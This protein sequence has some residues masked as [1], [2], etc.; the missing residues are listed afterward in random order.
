MSDFQANLEQL[1][2]ILE[3]LRSP[4]E[5]DGHPWAQSL[6]AQAQPGG[7]PGEK[8]ALAIRH[9]FRELLPAQPPRRGKRL[10]THWGAFGIL[11]AQYFVPQEF[12]LPEPQS[13]REAWLGID[14]AILLYVF[15]SDVEINPEQRKRYCLVGNEPEVAP[16][17]T[18]SGWN[19]KGLEALLEV[20][21]HH[22]AALKAAL[23]KKTLFEPA[24]GTAPAIDSLH[25]KTR[26]WRNVALMLGLLLLVF[27]LWTGWQGYRLYRQTQVV[28][29][30]VSSLKPV[31]TSLP[32]AGQIGAVAGQVTTLRQ[33]LSVL[34]TQAEPFLW[35]APYMRWVPTYG[36]DISQAPKILDMATALVA[37]A[38]EGLQVV[39]PVAKTVSDK[40][41]PLD[42]LVLLNQLQQEQP[43]LLAAQ[44][45]L[46][47]AQQARG[48]I[49]DHLLS[50]KTR[51]ILTGQID[52][53]LQ[54]VQGKF[55][56]EDALL[57]VKAAPGLLGV[58][59]AGPK[60]Y[61]LLIQNEDELRPTGGFITAVGSVVIRDG[62]LWDIKIESSELINDFSKPY[63]KAPWQLD[64]YMS[65]P[66]LVFSDSN[67]FSDFPTTAS[68]AEYL[69]SY[70]RAHSV[71]G[72]I[73]IN[74][75]VVVE[76]LKTLGPLNVPGLSF[77]INSDNILQ[78]MRTAKQHSPPGFVG[79][80]DR[81]LFIGKLAQPLL[82]KIL[83]AR[84]VQLSAL[85]QTL[86]K[87]LDERDILLQFDDPDLTTF[88]AQR[89]W[90]GAVRPPANS[91][92]LLLVDANVGYNKTHAV[93][94][95]ALTYELN[96]ADPA[97]PL[98][99]LTVN[100]TNHATGSLPCVP[101]PPGRVDDEAI[102]P[103]DRCYW[104]YLRVYTPAGTSLLGSTPHAIPA[105]ATMAGE[106]IPAKVDNLGSEDIPGVQVFGTLVLVPQR[107]TIQTSFEF[108]LPAAVLRETSAGQ[109]TYRLTIQ[110]QAGVLALPLTLR[111]NLPPAA[112][113][114]TKTAGLVLDQNTW[115]YS[116]L[117]NQDVVIEIS[118]ALGK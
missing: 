65:L 82:E 106:E 100:Q 59:K 58:G 70:A 74:Q 84:G 7:S 34:Q 96:L 69:Y 53:L 31:L 92:Y 116:T 97:K 85:A 78:Y 113:M 57:L 90:D 43:R 3:H 111:V 80:W 6:F 101:M 117:L 18:L 110:K 76:L 81:K 30:D 10:D 93:M 28:L 17:S 99:K 27:T 72:V 104:S 115:V 45:S 19:R 40:Q 2:N 8:L 50:E 22:E 108:G 51:S 23:N 89:K 87:L 73:A 114:L 63:P 36:G 20:V 67:W 25:P 29:R 103:I 71:D 98:A 75:N 49:Q 42:L 14:Q 109:W 37:A 11:A 88:L 60:T 52:P 38:D 5:L 95:T 68:M 41:Q 33:D 86:I 15:G 77:E 105:E 13:Q 9:H 91:D 102:Y 32:Q 64:Q 24:I 44:V 118:F 107:Q 46:A 112:K 79:V 47:Q 16:N 62:A 66:F 26:I 1:R 56:M 39:L 12:G 83:S 35:L 55:R 21:V 54:S 4:G 94:D 48:Q 61:L